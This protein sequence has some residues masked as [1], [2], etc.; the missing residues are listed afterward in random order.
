MTTTESARPTAQEPRAAIPLDQMQNAL[1]AGQA[2]PL[3]Q[4]ITDIVRYQ[5]NWWLY[6]R[7][8][9]VPVDNEQLTANLDAAAR[10]M[11]IAD[12]QAT[13]DFQP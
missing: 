2:A 12:R 5:S 7:D 9:W 1:A 13:V 6:D 11:A 8:G 10:E 4:T 3:S